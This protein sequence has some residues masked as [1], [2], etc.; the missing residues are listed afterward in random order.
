[1]KKLLISF[2]FSLSLLFSGFV[3]SEE[4][5]KQISESGNITITVKEKENVKD[6]KQI[7]EMDFKELLERYP[8]EAKS[9]PEDLYK[10]YEY[11]Q[12]RIIDFDTSF[13]EGSVNQVMGKIKTLY[14][15][16][17]NKLITLRLFSPGGSVIDMMRLY[18]FMKSLPTPIK[19][20]CNGYV[21]SAAAIIFISGYERE[22]TPLCR[23]LIHELSASTSGKLGSMKSDVAF[24]KS[25]NEQ[26]IKIIS[27]HSG[28]SEKDVKEIMKYDWFYDAYQAEKLGF[29][30]IITENYHKPKMEKRE[31]PKELNPGNLID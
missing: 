16:D 6:K 11:Y 7:Y 14:E 21:A 29:V 12:L 17:P 13:Y 28:L 26:G 27:E 19:T 20:I 4:T 9:S 18:D 3:L 1:M 30:D 15:L 24:F 23:L 2:I 10:I 31:L 22:A 8:L 25:L 5:G